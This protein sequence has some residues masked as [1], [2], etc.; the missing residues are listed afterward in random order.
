MANDKTRKQVQYEDSVRQALIEKFGYQNPHQVPR[1]E[2]ISVNMG[3]GGSM[4]DLKVLD[5]AIDAM[6]KFTG[7][8]PVITNARK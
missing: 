5:S 6:T 3:V 2:K 7:Q 1:L 8:K 4:G